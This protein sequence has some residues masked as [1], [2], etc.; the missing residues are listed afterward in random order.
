MYAFLTDSSDE[1]SRPGTPNVQHKYT[2]P[3]V[4]V[5]KVYDEEEDLDIEKQ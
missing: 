2:S 1:Y 4:T 3:A 5:A